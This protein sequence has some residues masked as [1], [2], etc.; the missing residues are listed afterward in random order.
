M[1]DVVGK[2]AVITGG[3]SG[4]GLAMARSFT[5]AGM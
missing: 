5:A 4:L 3:A 1:K 2:V